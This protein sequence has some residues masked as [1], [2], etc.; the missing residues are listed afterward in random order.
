MKNTLDTLYKIIEL[1]KLSPRRDATFQCL[2]LEMPE[3]SSAH[4]G[5]CALCPTRWSVC[6]QALKSIIDNY[7]VLQKLWDECLDFVKE[8]ETVAEFK[9]CQHA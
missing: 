4:A 9:E 1:I 6:A 3:D 2:K 7:E 8:R 5:I